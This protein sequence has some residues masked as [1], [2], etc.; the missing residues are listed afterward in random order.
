LN[1]LNNRQ[2]LGFSVYGSVLD[3]KR[4]RVMMT[5]VFGIFATIVPFLLAMYSEA[6]IAAPVYGRMNN[7]TRI[8]AYSAVVRDYATSAAFC[9]SLWMDVASVHTE[10]EDEAIVQLIGPD[11][12]AWVGGLKCGSETSGND[13]RSSQWKWEDGSNYDYMTTGTYDI[14]DGMDQPRLTTR[15][16]LDGAENIEWSDKPAS[17][18]FGV[19]CAATKLA[20]LKTAVP[21]IRRLGGPKNLALING[22]AM[23]MDP[24]SVSTSCEDFL[25]ELNAQRCDVLDLEECKSMIRGL[26]EVST[27]PNVCCKA[28]T[29]P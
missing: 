23:S 10:A 6:S 27:A 14:K 20:D 8:F 11:I 16:D 4:L 3:K 25:T 7:S 12:E 5:A 9:E 13:P 22:I 19:I 29:A 21:N 28:H 24:A 18:S 2:G 15:F 26:E 1:A 17:V